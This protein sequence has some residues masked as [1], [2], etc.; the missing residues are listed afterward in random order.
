MMEEDLDLVYPFVNG[1]DLHQFHQWGQFYIGNVRE[2]QFEEEILQQLIIPGDDSDQTIKQSLLQLVQHWKSSEGNP[3]NKTIKTDT[4]LPS[5]DLVQ[6]KNAGLII[7]LFG[8]PGTGKTLTPQV[9]L[10]AP[11]Q[12]RDVPQC[13]RPGHQAEFRG[14]RVPRAQPQDPPMELLGSNR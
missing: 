7:I 8:N 10:R 1:Y 6:Y 12:A 13:R 14:I 3:Q 9:P 4:P 11:P 5:A 2:I